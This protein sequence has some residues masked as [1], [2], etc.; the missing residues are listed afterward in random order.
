[1]QFLY[2]AGAWAFLGLAAVLALYILRREY[3]DHPISSTYLWQKTLQDQT[4]SKPF[5]KL[6]SNMLMFLQLLAVI[7]FAFSLMRPMLPGMETGGETVM[8]FDLSMSMQAQSAGQSRIEKAVS[9]AERM[10]SGM[11][12]AD[13][14]TIL[15]AGNKVS[16]LISRTGDRQAALQALRTVK[17]EYGQADIG[18]AMSLAAAMKREIKDMNIVL[19]SD[20]HDPHGLKGIQFIPTGESVD[21]RAIVALSASRTEQ[22][23]W[24]LARIANFGQAADVTVECYADGLLCDVR[25]ATLMAGETQGLRFVLPQ[26]AV[27]I[28]ARIVENDGLAADNT[29]YTAL[30]DSTKQKIAF[31]GQDNVF[32]EKALLQRGDVDLVRT[33]AADAASIFDCSLFVYD[34]VMP[35][36]MPEQGAVMILQPTASVFGV[37]PGA[38][39]SPEYGFAMP[40]GG[41]AAQL[42][43]HVSFSQVALR[44]YTPL[45]GGQPVLVS[46]SDTLIAAGEES[47]RRFMVIG[48][49]L[50]ESNWVMK[51]DFPIFMMH[52]LNYLMPNAMQ[53]VQDALCGDVL[54]LD[55]D[56]RTASASVLTP[57]GSSYTLAPPFPVLPFSDTGMPGLYTLSQTMLKGDT[58]EAAFAVNVPV[59]ESDVR[60]VDTGAGEGFQMRS[61]QYYGQE[62]TGLLMLALLALLLMEWWVSC[63]AG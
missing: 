41:I 46:G 53:N 31:I 12:A 26:G 40:A 14:V 33:T 59:S 62:L 4:A 2:P 9:E 55:L 35:D 10:L 27:R 44:Q 36:P 50:H 63:R 34:G 15:T 23:A 29:R 19:F 38:Q 57:G 21:N 11:G 43:D 60:F 49:D 61:T 24:A 37:T 51:Y 56:G 3:R 17:A 7:L 13:K 8:I 39:K 54:T 22:G 18:G 28:W 6:R 42:S 52:A 16:N 1:M 25:T 20:T 48:F 32:L 58:V 47:G 45:N 5:Q 30:K